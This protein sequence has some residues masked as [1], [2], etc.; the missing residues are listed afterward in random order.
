MVSMR[1][2]PDYQV[3]E[4]PAFMARL[5]PSIGIS[6]PV[7]QAEASDARKTAKHSTQTTMSRGFLGV[8]STGGPSKRNRNGY[9]ITTQAVV[10]GVA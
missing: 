10:F 4:A 9:G 5:P 7:T 8:V 3:W 6:A 1:M 2:V